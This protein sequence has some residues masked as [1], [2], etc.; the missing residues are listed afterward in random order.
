MHEISQNVPS[1]IR[2]ISPYKKPIPDLDLH[3]LQKLDEMFFCIK[4][5]IE[6]IRKNRI[7]ESLREVLS[8]V[9]GLFSKPL[10][11]G[12]KFYKLFK[13]DS[14][15]KIMFFN[16]TNG[17]NIFANIDWEEYI[18]EIDFRDNL[19]NQLKLYKR[20]VPQWRYNNWDRWHMNSYHQLAQLLCIEW[21]VCKWIEIDGVS[22]IRE[23]I[24]LHCNGT[25]TYWDVPDSSL[26]KIKVINEI[27]KRL[28]SY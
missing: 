27:F 8:S 4:L 21:W 1:S 11:N 6:G 12:G 23:T 7:K 2:V 28:N 26:V 17:L 9:D 15:E 14:P 18:L 16:T 24:T 10:D 13:L 25:Q 5:K 3:D 20:W 22:Q 19:E